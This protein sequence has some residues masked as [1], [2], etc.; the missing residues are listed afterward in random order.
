MTELSGMNIPAVRQFFDGARGRAA[1]Q[2][3]QRLVAGKAHPET[4][5]A[6]SKPK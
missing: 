4:G 2:Q 6:S 3:D 5:S 1:K